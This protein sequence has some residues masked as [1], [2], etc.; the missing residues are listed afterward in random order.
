MRKIIQWVLTSAD[1]YVCG[2][3]GEFDWAPLTPEM[4]EYSDG[5]H[6]RIDT[7]LYGRGVWEMFADYW[8]QVPSD[9]DADDRARR[10][11]K[12]WMET[13]KVVFSRTLKEVDGNARLIS[14][15][16]AEEVAA[17][18]EQPGKD[19]LITGGSALPASLTALGLIDEYHV[20]IHPIVLGGGKPLFGKQ[21]RIKLR[22]VDTRMVDSQVV[23]VHYEPSRDSSAG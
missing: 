11:A 7:F 3:N 5:L 15:N 17:L 19:M 23:I 6:E 1:G 4:A 13:P 14:D 2:P 20:A 10:F 8:P 16:I 9:P 12:L 22:M 21:D 18:K